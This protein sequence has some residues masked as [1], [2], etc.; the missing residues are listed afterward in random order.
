M[1]LSDYTFTISN[2]RLHEC[3]DIDAI[4]FLLGWD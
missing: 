3:K 4:R 1:F 2:P